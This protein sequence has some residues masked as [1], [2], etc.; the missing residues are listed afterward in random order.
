MLIGKQVRVRHA[1]NKLVPLYLDP[2]NPGWVGAAE[3]L[4][5][6]YRDAAGHT[7]GDL[8]DQLEGLLGDGPNQLVHQGLA[9]LL[10]DRCEFE[11]A[12]DLPPEAV[13]EAVFR[14][15]AGHAKRAAAGGTGFDRDAVLTA[16]A[17][18]LGGDPAAIDRALFA[19]LKAEQRV[20]T[21]ADLTPEQLVNRYNV[22]LAQ[23]VIARSVKLDVRVWAETPARYR[24]LF[25]AV[26]FHRLMAT[27]RPADGT[28]YVLALDGPLSLFSATQKYGGQLAQFLP[29]LL[30]CKAFELRA[31][32]RW[33]AEK[34]EKQFTLVPADGLKPFT[35]DF[36][37]HQPRE[38]RDF[39]SN[40]RDT[41][42]DWLLSD[43]PQL[44]PAAGTTWVPDFTLTHH[45]SGRAV[46]V[47]VLGFWRKLDIEAHYR[48]LKQA[49]PGQ[50]LLVVSEAYRTDE[51]TE[52][53]AGGEVYRYKRTPVAADVAAAAGRVAGV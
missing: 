49:L 15:S 36:G 23:A 47:E 14:L 41:V 4:L 52:F 48:R 50:F 51:A 24:Q 42:P 39:A 27:I 8:D 40:F 21:F 44:L 20:L 53:K 2:A 37:M 17:A 5:L 9:K 25:R 38:V 18:E 30:H 26:K 29:A 1:R 3:Q 28:S 46:H 19:D 32:V 35:A 45:K 6:A 33:G 11:V 12:S 43:D 16:A 34:K 13:R 31:E 7:R 22:A 10:E